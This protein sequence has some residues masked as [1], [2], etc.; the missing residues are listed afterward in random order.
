MVKHSLGNAE[1]CTMDTMTRLAK[2]IELPSGR[3]KCEHG[4]NVSMQ[5]KVQFIY[6]LGK[7]VV[8]A[9]PAGDWLAGF[10]AIQQQINC[11]VQVN[12]Y[13]QIIAHQLM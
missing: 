13:K 11:K 1:L 6:P 4:E 10:W 12:S 9:W 8:M 3:C 5:E 7:Q 2:A